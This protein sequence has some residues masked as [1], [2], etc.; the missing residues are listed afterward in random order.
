MEL[1]AEYTFDA[2]IARVWEVLMDPQSIA[3]C[4]PGCQK[5]EAI[6]DDRYQV[7]LTAGVAAITGSFSGTVVMADK[8]PFE[9]YRLIVEGRG[10]PGFVNGQS[11][12]TLRSVDGG[13]DTVVIAVAGTVTV[14]GLVAQVGQRLIGATA[15]LMMDRFF[16]C[17]RA[18]AKSA[19]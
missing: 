11:T 5:F 17:L 18:N 9:S 16:N 7:T 10:A 1:T 4:L 2:P 13:V 14:G 3:A 8:K 12:I 19:A 15:R 6:G